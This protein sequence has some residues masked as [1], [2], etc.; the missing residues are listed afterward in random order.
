MEKKNGIV[1]IYLAD[2]KSLHNEGMVHKHLKTGLWKTYDLQGHVILE[3]NYVDGILNG[4][5]TEYFP[6]G[7]IQIKGNY[8]NGILN[9]SWMEYFPSGN[10]RTKGNYTNGIKTGQW[11]QFTDKRTMVSIYNYASNG[12]PLGVQE[13]FGPLGMIA[14]YSIIDSA[15]NKRTYLYDKWGKPIS[16]ES[17]SGNKK[18]G[19]QYFYNDNY[20][21]PTDTFPIKIENYVNGK[22]EGPCR[23]YEKGKLVKEDNYKNDSVNGCCR[24]WDEHGNLTDSAFFVNGQRDG[25]EFEYGE[26][27]LYSCSTYTM[28]K[29]NGPSIIYYYNGKIKSCAWM[30]NNFADST[31]EFYPDGNRK[32]CSYESKLSLMQTNVCWSENKVKVLEFEYDEFHMGCSTVEV[33][34]DKG[35]LLKR[36]TTEYNNQIKKYLPATYVFNEKYGNI[37]PAFQDNGATDDASPTEV[38]PDN[39]EVFVYAEVMPSFKSEEGTF[40]DYLQANLK[41][42][43][44]EKE[45]GKQGTVYVS[46][47]V[48]KD[49]SIS[50]VK[51]VKE[52]QGAPGFTK[53]SI[54]VILE[55]PNWNPGQMNGKNVR[56]SIIQPV[57]F[58]LQ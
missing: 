54:R 7:N 42:P 17:F 31:V 20:R 9:D 57:K 33:R 13:I 1:K 30:Y 10:I 18:N 4:L 8:T 19:L 50:S 21:N 11:E 14:N 28:G 12:N 58:I 32:S 46:F 47:I 23:Y 25:K 34:S 55:M 5:F 15:K 2:T 49:G 27:K 39:D 56:V 51:A 16:I 22:L 3:D 38:K 41:F 44:L 48:E 53:E 36:G 43:E 52:V 29:K 6:N 40:L 35:I 45:Y 24:Q 26:G 37:D